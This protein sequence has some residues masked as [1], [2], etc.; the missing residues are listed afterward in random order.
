MANKTHKINPLSSWVIDAF[1]TPK[2]MRMPSAAI[3]ISPN[4]VKYLDSRYTSKGV[5]PTG[6]KEVFLPEGTIVDGVIDDERAFVEAL[7]ELR[8]HSKHQFVFVSMPESALYLYTMVVNRGLNRNNIL[9]Q[10]EFSFADNVPIN[11]EEAVYDFD[12]IG[13][14]REGV[15]ISVTVAPRA[16]VEDYHK[17]LNEA[18]F[19][20]RSLELEAYAITRSVYTCDVAGAVEMIVDVGHTRAG[21]IIAKSGLPIFSITVKGGKDMLNKVVDECKK[22]YTFWDTQTNTKGRRVDRI[23][24]V[25]ICGGA[26][27]EILEPLEKRL[28]VHIAYANVWQHLFDI[29]DFIPDITF[30]QSLTTATLAGLLLNNKI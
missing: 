9:Q 14:S 1:P 8:Q 3:D 29:N 2:Y 23:K 20:T 11:I 17:A 21:I 5:L 7:N 13:E 6:F 18:G 26:A 28:G 10:I 22:Q 12:I 27:E 16:V 19:V 15:A 4:S 25:L 24:K 30:H